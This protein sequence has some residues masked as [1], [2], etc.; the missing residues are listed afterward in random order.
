MSQHWQ[1]IKTYQSD[2]GKRIRVHVRHNDEDY[3]FL[4]VDGQPGNAKKFVPPYLPGGE[5]KERFVKGSKAG[6]RFAALHLDTPSI[7]ER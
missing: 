4:F 6:W 2:D 1:H 7:P 5:T 3:R